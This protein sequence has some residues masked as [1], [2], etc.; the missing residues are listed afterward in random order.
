M[1]SGVPKPVFHSDALGRE[2]EREE[3]EALGTKGT[4]QALKGT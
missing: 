1:R 3:T 4:A 2:V